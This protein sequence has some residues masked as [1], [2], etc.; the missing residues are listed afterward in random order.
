MADGSTFSSSRIP[1]YLIPMAPGKLAFAPT[2]RITTSVPDALTPLAGSMAKIAQ[3]ATGISSDPV[4]ASDGEGESDLLIAVGDSDFC[5][6]S[7]PNR[8]VA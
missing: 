8:P 5:N 6:L 2:A 4:Q 7:T 1:G 3:H